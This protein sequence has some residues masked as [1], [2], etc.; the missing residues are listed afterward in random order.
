MQRSI[1]TPALLGLCVL[2]MAATPA[3]VND[4]PTQDRV[5]YVQECIRAHPGPTFEMTSKCSCALDA[6]AAN[7]KYKDYVTMSTITKALSIGGERGGA[8]RDVPSYEPEIKR[9]RDLQAK[10]EKAC[11]INPAPK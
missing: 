7:V 9:L 4:F 5:L 3:H 11:F 1:T 8:I 10:A 6:L 2:L